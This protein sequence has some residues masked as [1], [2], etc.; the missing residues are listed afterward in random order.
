MNYETTQ[1]TADRLGISIHTVR[2]WA[3]EDR[4]PGAVRNGRSWM[5]PADFKPSDLRQSPS[6]R[7]SDRP[8]RI[9]MPLMNSAYPVG[10]CRELIETI[11]DEDLRTIAWG[12][13]FY[14]RGQAELAAQTMEPYQNS[15]DPALRYSAGLVLFFTSFTRGRIQQAMQAFEQLQAD[16]QSDLKEEAP[17]AQLAIGAFAVTASSVLLHLPMGVDVD[18]R[19]YMPC[20]PEGLKLWACYLLAHS[21]YLERN[22]HG[23][24]AVAELA[25]AMTAQVYPIATIYLHLVIVMNLMSLRRVNEAR[26]HMAQAWALARPD[27]LIEPFGEHHGLLQGMIERFFQ[28]DDPDTYE[29]I[30]A[31]TYTFSAG[32]RKIHRMVSRREVADNLTTTEFTIAMLYNRGWTAKEIAAYMSLSPRTITNAIQVIY[33]KLGISGKKEL[34]QF[35]LA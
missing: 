27:G 2:K 32:W 34:G 29:R 21:M 22:Y 19:R 11:P 35:M 30:I 13:Y 5:I 20:L 6:K 31:I 9:A 23:S 14:F 8:A 7:A 3:K 17:P 26:Q 16:L 25:L 18:L 15:D 10:S 12:E 33:Q 4:I 28:K 1:Q 24:L